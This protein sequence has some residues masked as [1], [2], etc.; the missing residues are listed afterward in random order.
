MSQL[1][2]WVELSQRKRELEA[3]LLKVKAE[4]AELSESIRTDWADEGVRSKRTAGGVLVH[5]R[6]QI[7]ARA[8]DGDR[9]R[10]AQ[11]LRALPEFEHL[12]QLDFN[13]NSLSAVFRQ[14][15]KEAAEEGVYLSLGQLLPAGLVGAIALD[16]DIELR[17]RTT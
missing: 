15:A 5:T 7:W 11:A 13:V 10:A 1:D 8:A 4:L 14:K 3:E 12:A 9:A 16:E 6:R 17:L 2:Q